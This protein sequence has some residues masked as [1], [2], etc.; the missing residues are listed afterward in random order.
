MLLEA[1][2]AGSGGSGSDAGGSRVR[3]AA[4]GHREMDILDTSRFLDPLK[5][6]TQTQTQAQ[7]RPFTR[8]RQGGAGS[9]VNVS[10][11]AEMDIMRSLVSLDPM[12]T[13]A[14][15]RAQTQHPTCQQQD[16][17]VFDL[18]MA[19][20]PPLAEYPCPYPALPEVEPNPEFE[21]ML[22]MGVTSMQPTLQ[23]GVEQAGNAEVKGK[24]EE[25]Q[26]GEEGQEEEQADQD[27]EEQGLVDRDLDQH[28]Y[29]YHKRDLVDTWLSEVFD[30]D[31]DM[32]MPGCA[33]PYPA[34]HE[35]V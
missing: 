7:T 4:N 17:L 12:Q 11:A 8:Q 13:R 34:S 31:M 25:M 27:Q 15:I 20:P 18:D 28:P 3:N 19:P 30:M 32:P 9:G 22:N 1:F 21:E 2:L 26:K 5:N 10:N 14:Q 16:E 35:E 24:E 33:Y 6:Q 23:P 29:Q